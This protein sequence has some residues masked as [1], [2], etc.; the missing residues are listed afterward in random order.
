MAR[1][2]YGV[3]RTDIRRP[4][5]RAGRHRERKWAILSNQR[6]QRS[7]GDQK[8]I[9]GE[10]ILNPSLLRFSTNLSRTIAGLLVFL[11][12]A[13]FLILKK[14]TTAEYQGLPHEIHSLLL[15]IL[16]SA[17]FCIDLA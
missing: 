13:R 6:I 1:R 15:A 11:E 5:E 17:S 12:S 14:R 2:S 16:S 8:P 3:T 9:V 4:D 7:I 10:A